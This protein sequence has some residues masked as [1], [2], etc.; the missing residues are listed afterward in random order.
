MA[1]YSASESA[2]DG[3]ALGLTKDATWI[4]VSPVALSAST[5]ATR[6]AKGNVRFSIWKPSRGPSSWNST[7]RGRSDIGVLRIRPLNSTEY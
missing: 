1:P 6:S 7:K 5:T 3:T 2:I 4:C